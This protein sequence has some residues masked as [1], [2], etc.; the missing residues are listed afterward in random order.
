MGL[1][2]GLVV[3]L[4]VVAVGVVAGEGLCK[5]D[6]V[7]DRVAGPVAQIGGHAVGS[8]PDD[9][10]AAAHITRECARHPESGGRGFARVMSRVRQGLL[11]DG[12]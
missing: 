5:G 1:V 10:V 6:G 3:G 4:A 12:C 9:D 2:V 8:V 7:D 11:H